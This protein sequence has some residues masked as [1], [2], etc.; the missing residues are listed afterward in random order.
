MK[1]EEF[2]VSSGLSLL[3]GSILATL[4]M[5]MHPLGGNIEHISKIKNVLIFSHSTAIFCL[6]FVGFG[7]LGLTKLLQ[8]K[9][10]LST[11]AFI[12]CCFGLIAAMIA[13]TIN[14]LTLPEFA[15]AY[16]ADAGAVEINERIIRYGHCINTPMAMILIFAFSLA[17][18]IWSVIIVQTGK[19]P[20]RIG[21]FGLVIILFGLTGIFF[22]FNFADLPGFRFFV[23]GL[24]VWKIAVGISLLRSR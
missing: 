14:G 24:V 1:D 15:T 2:R 16:A 21:Y 13:A 7:F 22:S 9:S 5:V 20:V 19:L 4:T 6:P 8:T 10:K 17:V 3:V 12:I 18:A 11:L 23:G